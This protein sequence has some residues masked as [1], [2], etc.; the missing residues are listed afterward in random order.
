[1]TLDLDKIK[2][3]IE[4]ITPEEIEKYFPDRNIPKGWVSI[5]DYLPMMLA[6]DVVKGYTEYK[7]KFKDES[8]GVTCISDHTMWYYYAK[9]AGVKYW[10]N[11]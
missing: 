7:V 9:E 5:E 2:K 11:E 1:M 8:E 4:N 6:M 10:W 3:L